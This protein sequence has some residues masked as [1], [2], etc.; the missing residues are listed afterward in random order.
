MAP[1]TMKPLLLIFLIFTSS[2]TA[3]NVDPRVVKLVETLLQTYLGQLNST[4]ILGIL[5]DPRG[6]V[7]ASQF[8]DSLVQVQCGPASTVIA[9]TTSDS[10]GV[11][12]LLVDES[13]F[14]PSFLRNNCTMRVS[15]PPS[16]VN[17]LR[18][19][20][21]ILNFLGPVGTLASA[22]IGAQVNLMVPD[23]IQ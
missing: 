7:V 18:G 10:S 23:L 6:L 9:A 13:I 19:V 12:A 4:P 5:L 20:G 16:T 21:T 14:P 3:V 15:A 8:V 11:A 22:S 17:N 2:A 1:Y